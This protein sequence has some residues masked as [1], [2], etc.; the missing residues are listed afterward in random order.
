MCI[1]HILLCR[2]WHGRDYVG[3]P[4]PSRATPLE[5]YGDDEYYDDDAF[6]DFSFLSYNLSPYCSL[7]VVTI[8]VI[9]IIA[10]LYNL[11]WW[12]LFYAFVGERTGCATQ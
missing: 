8:I 4:P 7:K 11:E 2:C 12:I 1:S 9:I 3:L 6:D 5:A 10:I